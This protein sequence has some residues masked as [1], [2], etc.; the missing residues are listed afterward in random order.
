MRLNL[1]QLLT[2]YSESFTFFQK[3]KKKKKQEQNDRYIFNLFVINSHK[4][5]AYNE[6]NLKYFYFRKEKKRKEK[7]PTQS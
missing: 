1:F 4:S 7:N 3:K 5:H 6:L 2:N